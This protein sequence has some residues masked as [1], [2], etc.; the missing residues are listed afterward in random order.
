[1]KEW[2]EKIRTM[3]QK[4]T[5]CP[6]VDRPWLKYY[7]KEAVSAPRPEET[8]YE[9]LYQHNK[10]YFTQTALEYFGT[11]ISFKKRINKVGQSA[12]FTAGKHKVCNFGS[13]RRTN[14][15]YTA[16]AYSVCP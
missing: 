6:S 10:D 11:K 16:G 12:D 13:Y 7:S 9:Y 14:I 3:Q 5:G 4:Q 2:K 1:M 15:H 8:V